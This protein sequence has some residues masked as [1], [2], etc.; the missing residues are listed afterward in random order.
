MSGYIRNTA[1]KAEHLLSQFP[2]VAIIGARQTGKTTL[3]KMLRPTWRY[4]DLENSNHYEQVTL[5]MRLFLENNDHDLIIDEA[6]LLPDL[7]KD[8]RG[9]VDNKRELKGR[10][11]ITGSSSPDLLN[12]VS[13]TLAG[14]IAIVELGTLKVNEINHFPMGDFYRLF[15]SKLDRDNLPTGEPPLLRKQIHNAW[16]KG[17]YPEPN[18]SSTNYHQWMESYRST[19]INRDIAH[20]F[21]QLNKVAYQRFISMLAQLSGT[22]VN[23]SELGRSVEVSEKTI[24]D[25][26]DIANG[27]FLWRQLLSY[28]KSTSKSITKMPKGHIRDTGLLHYLL[29]IETMD[30]LENHPIIGRSFEGFV[31]EE[32][33]KGLESSEITNW[34]AYYFRTKNGAEVDLILDGFFGVLPIEIKYGNQVNTKQLRHLHQFIDANNCSF[35][36]LINQAERAEWL[37]PTVYQLPVGFL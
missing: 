35:G 20:L 15:N 19:Y 13:E 3:A 30:D 1:N 31:I 10:F 37:T 16:L 27:T 21:P 4:I 14:R 34:D 17:G 36:L 9:V 33:L 6:Q 8:L 32:I 24:R 22:I 23:K 26:F 11:I 5:D 12:H 25:Y 28:E 18:L 29:R 7:L 2:V